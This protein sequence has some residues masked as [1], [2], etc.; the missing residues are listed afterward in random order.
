MYASIRRYNV[1][2]GSVEEIARRVQ[3]GFVPIITK[4]PGFLSYCVVDAGDGVVASIS[5]FESRDAAQQSNRE[6]ANYV[7]ANLAE[8]F[9][10]APEITA[11]E[12][13]VQAP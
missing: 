11:G 1:E 5:I 13:V 8:F 2:P 4:I 6:A 7:R 12:V 3:D 9:P 10:S